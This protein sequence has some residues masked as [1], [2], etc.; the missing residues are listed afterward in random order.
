MAKSVTMSNS[1]LKLLYQAVTWANVA[2][3]ATASPIG[4]VYVAMHTA[5]PTTAGDQTTSEISYTSYAR[6]AVIRDAT[7]WTV[8]NNVVSPAA[9][10]VFPAST[11]GTPTATHFS[12][13]Q[14]VS[15]AGVRWHSGTITPNIVVSTSV[16]QT[17]T[18]GSTITES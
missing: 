2:I 7:G 12:T 3:N 16:V 17:L 5:D 11:G 8:T 13:G 6:Q 4:Y 15:G 9:N 1:L 18:T 14:A 10:I